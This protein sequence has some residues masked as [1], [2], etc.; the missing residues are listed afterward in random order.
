MKKIVSML[1]A[2]LIV[3]SSF[4][5]FAYA[6]EDVKKA[7]AAKQ[8]INAPKVEIALVFDSNSENSEI[9]YGRNPVIEALRSE[10]SINKFYNIKVRWMNNQQISRRTLKLA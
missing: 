3:S 8:A 2:M 5:Q 1:L 9:L 6:I 7:P 4:G 10:M